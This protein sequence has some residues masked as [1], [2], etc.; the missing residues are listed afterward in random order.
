MSY[1]ASTA[2]LKSAPA[3]TE[4]KSQIHSQVAPAPSAYLR[5]DTGEV[6]GVPASDLTQLNNEFDKWNRLIYEQL[7]ANEVLAVCDARLEA[8]AHQLAV[9]EKSVSED[10]I[11]ESEKAQG[12][13]LEWREKAT[14]K[15]RTEL[16]PLDKLGGAGK[17]LVELIPLAEKPGDSLAAHKHGK[18]NGDWKLDGINPK[19]A[20]S[21]KSAAGIR[22]HFKQVER[23]KG[24]GPLRTIPSDK[25][26]T[27][28]PKAKDEKSMKWAEVYKKE[29]GG[30]RKIDRVKMRQYLGEQVQ[31]IKGK[32]SDLVK[33]EISNTGTLGPEVLANW[34]ANAT[35]NKEGKLVF[36]DTQYGDIDLSAEAAA[37]RYFTGG[38]LSG[39]I[40]PL[41]GNVNIKAEGSAEIAF[42]EG[43]AGASLFL[44]SKEGIMLYLLDIKQ[45]HALA[46]GKA[47]PG[48][49]YDMG[50][51]RMIAAA[52]LKGVIGVSIAGEVSLGVAMKDIETTDLDGKKKHAKEARLSGK[53]NK[54]KRAR[55]I[56]VT[57]Q[58]DDWKNM[59][60]ATAEVSLF[61]GAKGG[62]ELKGSL[63][64]RNPHSENKEFEAMA[65]IA[66]E[67]QGQ[68]GIG[69]SAKMMIDYVDGVFRITA[70]AGICF[71]VGAEGTVSFAVN[72]KQIGSF[73]YWLYYNLLNVGFRNLV[74]LSKAAFKVFKQLCYLMVCQGKKVEEYFLKTGD[75]LKKAFADMAEK[76]EKAQAS[77]DLGKRILAN[78]DQT[79]FSPPESKG[80]LIYQL[81]RHGKESFPVEPG[82]GSGYL[83]T[84][85]SA[86]LAILH[87][88][89]LKADIENVIQ[90]I[91][92]EGAKGS[93]SDNL[94]M[95]K[96]FFAL[97]GPGGLNLPGTTVQEDEFQNILRRAG[98]A[99]Q[100]LS[101]ARQSA[102]GEV[103]QIAM[104]GDFGGWYDTVTGTLKEEST[105]G[106]VAV[107][108]NSME[109]ALQRVRDRDHPLFASA[110]GGFYSSVA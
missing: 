96:K 47:M 107:A 13:A 64:W 86:V 68:A 15:L 59:A 94:T 12:F 33:L 87:Q 48:K 24:V 83:R 49:P 6:I 109:Y 2:E 104:N 23:Y 71:G 72:V 50:A 11:K 27:A 95:L 88:T 74:I 31:G 36:G 20:W 28:W 77:Y 16:A 66:P 93:F 58:A 79:R 73:I 22:D 56:D 97:E 39:E 100:Q 3:D 103:D 14:E 38:S 41:K 90:H 25:L 17:K 53:R 91:D 76:Y 101:A 35:F 45:I 10:V 30:K 85:K 18:E 60:G 61:A 21:F 105:R 9:Q 42:A 102:G 84:Q 43:K 81:T 67:V 8:I 75:D 1:V 46:K 110:E 4:R 52:E 44:P 63:Q 99:A 55:T 82:L 34:N 37:M 40:A 106:Y 69:A 78:P 32:S 51:V 70:H 80:I 29:K 19:I 26:K 7:L 98:F 57:G 5:L 62:L 65:S 92:P 54:N 108:N 89:Q